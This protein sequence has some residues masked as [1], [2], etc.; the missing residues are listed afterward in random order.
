[1]HAHN[2]VWFE[3]RSFSN[4]ARR[5]VDLGRG[6]TCACDTSS[7][8]SACP[9]ANDRIFL[10]GWIHLLNKNVK[11]VRCLRP[12]NNFK[13]VSSAKT[14]LFGQDFSDIGFDVV[15]ACAQEHGCRCRLSQDQENIG[16]RLTGFLH[17]IPRYFFKSIGNK[18]FDLFLTRGIHWFSACHQVLVRRRNFYLF[19]FSLR[20][21]R[22]RGRLLSQDN[23]R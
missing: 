21:C 4:A 20:W 13:H 2:P 11:P 1:M 5:S 18:V 12:T 6:K 16:G 17:I 10:G 3:F 23:G 8:K 19:R 9:H 15:E 14:I 7:K 22:R